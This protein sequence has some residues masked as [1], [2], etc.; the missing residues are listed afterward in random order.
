MTA[1]ELRQEAAVYAARA[2]AAEAEL[3][4]IEAAISAATSRLVDARP[5]ERGQVGEERSRLLA[6]RENLMAELAELRRRRD[7]GYIGAQQLTVDAVRAELDR[8]A[9]AATAARREM[10]E[11]M[12]GEYLRFLNRGGRMPDTEE[13]MRQRVI[14][15]TKAAKLKTESA[16]AAIRCDRARGVW[17]RELAALEAL[18]RAT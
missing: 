5:E 18:K 11:F 16:I 17:Q 14:M 9:E 10:Q 8:L 3:S 2:S 1:E 6:Q 7:A 12:N 13:A 15:E 4:K